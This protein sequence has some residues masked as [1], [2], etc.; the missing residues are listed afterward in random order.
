MRGKRL[1]GSASAAVVLVLLAGLA[2]AQTPADGPMG[3][4][5]TY[6]GQLK[7]DGVPYT[8]T[9]D[10]NV[11][12]WDALTGGN[13]LANQTVTN[14]SV[15][16]GLFTIQLDYGQ[17]WFNGQA[18]WLAIAVRCPA[19]GGDYTPLN[20]RQPL[21]PA[22]YA[23][24]AARAGNA[25]L[26]AGNA[27]TTPGKDYLGTSDDV[28]LELRVNG[29]RA[30]RLE[31][32]ATSPNV[33][34]GYGGN[35]LEPGVLGATIG[36]GGDDGLVNRVTDYYGTVGGGEGNQAGDNAGTTTDAG[37]ATVGG[38]FSSI[39]S[40]ERATVAG[41]GS[42]LA[43]GTC[44]TVGG[45]IF[46]TAS[47]NSA[48]VGGGYSNSASG[49]GATVSGGENCAAGGNYATVSG[50]H[51]NSASGEGA[52]VSGGEN[53]AAGGTYAT[54]GGGHGNSATGG[55]ATVSGGQYSIA[56]GQGA[57]VGGGENNTAGGAYAAIAGGAGN[58][59]GA[60]GATVPGGLDAAASHYGEMAYSSGAF[61]VA[62]DAQTSVYVLR[63][64]YVPRSPAT[65][66]CE[67]TLNR[68]GERLTIGY[69]RT[70]VFD[71]LVTARNSVGDSAG[72][73]VRGVIE[74][75]DGVV[76]FVGTPLVEILAEDRPEWH[77][78][79]GASA[80]ALILEGEDGGAVQPPMRWVAV[81]RTVEVAF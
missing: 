8:G 73:R 51:G 15:T 3:T 4:A 64:G 32:N 24:Y 43:S 63:C 61:E 52:T 13:Q 40:G 65:G 33:I 76:S 20:P 19:G 7:S 67:M 59:T 34:G 60:I 39:A 77:I 50:G 23:L 78:N 69:N 66:W 2:L 11:G 31:P 68:G 18:R 56:G 45:G 49:E 71:I 28:A 26:L 57:F 30:L 17:D 6:Q 46:G 27:G 80:S 21:T 5:F 72:Y 79:I 10:L 70:V 1:F 75:V 41:G 55:A 42:N 9:C 62:G 38:G 29:A 48:T 16:G 54:V 58:V 36:G 37:G 53:D 14:V 81:V 47:G 12:L 22:P 25:W 35:W 44:A 74:N